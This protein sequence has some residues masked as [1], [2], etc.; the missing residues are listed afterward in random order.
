MIFRDDF[1][2][3]EDWFSTESHAVFRTAHATDTIPVDKPGGVG[4]RYKRKYRP[5]L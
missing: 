4:I 2:V 5:I 1:L 3:S